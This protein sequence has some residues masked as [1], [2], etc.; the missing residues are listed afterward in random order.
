MSERLL[1]V[2]D[3][4]M[5]VVV[6]EILLSRKGG[7]LVTCSENGEEILHMCQDGQV[8]LVLMDISLANTTVDGNP[9]DGLAFTRMIKAIRPQSPIILVTA[10]AMKGDRERFLSE[11]GADDYVSKPILDDQELFAKIRGLL[12]RN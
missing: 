8:D 2:E 12:R 6:L 3:D 4:P 11:T 7:F 5:N 10:H 9:V 1:L